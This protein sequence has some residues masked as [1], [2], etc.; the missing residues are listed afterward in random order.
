M[1]RLLNYS[2]AFP[3]CS[4]IIQKN[5]TEDKPIDSCHS[6]QGENREDVSLVIH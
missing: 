6:R 5:T 3:V 2:L 1:S 4:I